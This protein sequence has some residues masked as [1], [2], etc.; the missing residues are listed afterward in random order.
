M[1]ITQR[2][3]APQVI[4]PA[5]LGTIASTMLLPILIH[6][7]P[8]LNNI[9]MGA[10]LL[11]IFFAPLVALYVFHPAVSLLASLLTPYLNQLLTGNPPQAMMLTLSAELTLFSALCLLVLKRF[12]KLW[13]VAPLAYIAA[14]ALAQLVLKTTQLVATPAWTNFF[15]SLSLALP[16]LVILLILNILLARLK[17]SGSK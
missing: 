2:L 3:Q 5:T 9:P 11:P 4:V 16:G 14:K 10:R 6:A 17:Q 7:I 8:S 1:F 13:F 15:P 12:P